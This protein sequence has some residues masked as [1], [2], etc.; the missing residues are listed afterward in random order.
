MSVTDDFEKHLHDPKPS[1]KCYAAK[2]PTESLSFVAEVRH[3][4]G[5]PAT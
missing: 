1:F 3:K 5:E 4:I 2:D